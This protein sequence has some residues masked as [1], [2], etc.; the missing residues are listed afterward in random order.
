MNLI[1]FIDNS[2][3]PNENT[4]VDYRYDDSRFKLLRT[5]SPKIKGVRYEEITSNILTNLGYEVSKTPKGITEYDRI[6]N[7]KKIELKGSCLNKV[8][9]TK[10]G[11][12]IEKFSFLQIRPLQDY[13]E[14]YFSMFYTH[15]VIIMSLTKD[16]IKELINAGEIRPQ[17]GGKSGDSH[18]YMLYGNKETLESLGAKYISYY[19]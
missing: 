13:D 11:S 5:L 14:I 4:S 16:R 2:I 10:D 15:E 18:T 19:E 3:I 6:V 12:M 17:H 8:M 7:G 1:D 9:P